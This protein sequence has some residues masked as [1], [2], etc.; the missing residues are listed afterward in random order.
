MRLTRLASV[1]LLLIFVS[2]SPSAVAGQEPAASAKSWVG[3]QQEIEDYLK[4]AEIVDMSEIGI[5]VTNP[6]QATLAPGGPVGS[7]S[8]KPGTPGESYKAEIAAYELDKLLGLNMVPVTVE[9][10]VNGDLGAAKMWVAPTQSFEQIGGP[11]TPPTRHIGMWDLQIIRAK[12]F[13]SLIYNAD[14]N[15]GNWLVDPSWNLI[16][17]D[18]NRAFTPLRMMSH[19][20]TKIDI[21]LWE[22]MKALDE[23]TL[24]AVLGEWLSAI[25]IRAIL[26]RREMMERKINNLTEPRASQSARACLSGSSFGDSCLK[27]GWVGLGLHLEF[28]AGDQWIITSHVRGIAVEGPSTVTCPQWLVHSL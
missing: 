18:H 28:H 27:L 7:I 9:K 5:G 10:R 4:T 20:L 16:L 1:W 14:L 22:K 11:P 2:L 19:E 15:L 6:M 13:D 3:R 24:K 12:M 23:P 17:I 25:E 21:D 8:W 26:E